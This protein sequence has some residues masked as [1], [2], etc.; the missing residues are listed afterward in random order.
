MERHCQIGTSLWVLVL[1]LVLVVHVEP[2]DVSTHS[3]QVFFF[4]VLVYVDFIHLFFVLMD[5][6]IT[7]NMGV[8]P[9]RWITTAG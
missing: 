6:L 7:I 8:R 4:F 1:V 3:Q 5:M 9:L 2:D